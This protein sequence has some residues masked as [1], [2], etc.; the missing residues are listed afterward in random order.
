MIDF[1]RCGTQKSG[2]IGY[3]VRIER[4]CGRAW[5]RES[6]VYP[7]FVCLCPLLHLL[8]WK[9]AAR[10]ICQLNKRFRGGWQREN[11]AAIVPDCEM[12]S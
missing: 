4:I 6:K 10:T 8:A 11:I 3:L 9:D 12:K 5:M 7:V 1:L 2:R